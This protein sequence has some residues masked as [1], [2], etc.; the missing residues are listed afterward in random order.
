MLIDTHIHL[1]HARYDAD[2][3]AVIERA[4]EA[5]VTQMVMPAIGLPSIEQ[6]LDLC[7]RYEG[8]YA[9]T[10]LHP[11]EVKDATEAD[12]AAVADYCA[13]PKVVAVGE[14]G[15]DYYWD[16]S[17]D[18][19]QQAYL[20]Q[21]IQLALETDL[22]LILH[23]RDRS[24]GAE[25]FAD[26]LRLLD[27]EQQRHPDGE[28]LRGIFH[29]FGGPKPVIAKKKSFLLGIGGTLTF[30][31]SGVRDL[32]ADIPLS[33]M[34]LETDGPFLAPTP[35]RGKRNEPAYVRLV[36]EAMA[37]AQGCSVEEVAASTTA[38]AQKL[39]GIG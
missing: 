36:A 25:V 19:K 23:S 39:F 6:A 34:V 30:K 8:L 18:D 22:P 35:H 7:E 5:G 9:M 20:R 2:R 10:A 15:L 29:C 3:E 28:T 27:E 26:I 17:F 11:A 32:V 37:A 13:H 38:T 33:E 21:H 31:N 14:S 12:F 24:G 16:R 1:Y 4:W